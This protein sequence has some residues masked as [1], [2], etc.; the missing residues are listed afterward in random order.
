MIAI[1]AHLKQLSYLNGDGSHIGALGVEA[2]AKGLPLLRDLSL[3]ECGVEESGAVIIARSLAHLLK[4][5]LSYNKIGAEGG[6][7]LAQSLSQLEWLSLA[8]NYLERGLLKVSVRLS[9]PTMVRIDHNNA[10]SFER[11]QVRLCL[12]DKG[13]WV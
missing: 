2:V 13:V 5:K 12:S 11:K 4:L 3:S 10:M 8:H 6:E 9:K 1:A 7:I